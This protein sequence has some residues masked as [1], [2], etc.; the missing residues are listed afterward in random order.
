M[1]SVVIPAFNEQEN[2]PAAAERLGGILAPLS[3]YELIFVDDGSKDG[4][5]ELI[6][7]AR[8]NGRAYKR[9]SFFE[10]FRQRGSRFCRT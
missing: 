4:T 9:T 3:D 1:I 7:T 5:W 6:K 10:K 2:I 8:R